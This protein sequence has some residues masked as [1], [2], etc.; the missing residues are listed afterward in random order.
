[1]QTPMN[2]ALGAPRTG[3]G[4]AMSRTDAVGRFGIAT[5]IVTGTN[6]GAGSE[7]EGREERGR[8]REN[9]TGTPAGWTTG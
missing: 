7:T 5:E 2:A 6:Q 3:S 8:G 4:I 1:M 9:M